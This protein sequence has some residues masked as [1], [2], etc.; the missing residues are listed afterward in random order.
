MTAQHLATMSMTART[1][2]PMQANPITS[3]VASIR[4]MEN[5]LTPR[6][7]EIR[8]YGRRRTAALVATGLYDP[9]YP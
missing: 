4:A 8:E 7:Q 2:D 9:V 6:Q 1:I 5:D 3:I